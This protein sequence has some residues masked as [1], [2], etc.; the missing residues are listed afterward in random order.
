MDFNGG[1]RII[2][3]AGKYI[4]LI[5]HPVGEDRLIIV[6]PQLEMVIV[7]TGGNYYTKEKISCYAIVEDYIIPALTD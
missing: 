6:I 4:T 7:F 1:R 2:P 3:L 5:L